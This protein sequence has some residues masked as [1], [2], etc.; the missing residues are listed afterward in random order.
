MICNIQDFT[1]CW[2][3]AGGRGCSAGGG[4]H[5][6]KPGGGWSEP[7]RPE[8]TLQGTQI[9][10]FFKNIF[11]GFFFRTVFNTVSSADPQIP[12]CRRM[13]GTNPGPLQ[14]VHWQ[15]DALTTTLDLIRTTLDLIR[16]TLDLRNYA[17][18]HPQISYKIPNGQ[19][20]NLTRVIFLNIM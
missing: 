5:A 6:E 8:V 1:H 10:L 13:V 11:G 7:C 17:R 19:S 14:L 4:G 9:I 12:L 20:V 18:S 15:S 3:G 16:T 2:L